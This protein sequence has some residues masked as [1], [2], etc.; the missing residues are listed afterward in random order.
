MAAIPGIP[1]AGDLVHAGKR[2]YQAKEA[3]SEGPDGAR[4]HFQQAT[5][6]LA[7]LVAVEEDWIAA[8]TD[9]ATLDSLKVVRD[10]NRCLQDKLASSGKH[11]GRGAKS[12]FQHGTSNK[13]RF[14]FSTDKTVR[15]HHDRLQPAREAASMRIALCVAD[16]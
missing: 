16:C 2:L 3:L 15:E 4:Q 6:G 9:T 10:L 8:A 1:G 13:L 12:G 7:Q 11:L 14:G 5:S